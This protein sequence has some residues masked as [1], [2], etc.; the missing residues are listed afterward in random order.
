[1]SGKD[2]RILVIKLGA[3]GDFVQALGPM[4][5]IRH[6]HADARITLLT[7][8]PYRNLALATGV[9]DDVWID[10]RRSA[11]DPAYWLRLRRRLRAGRFAR[12]YDLQTSDRSGW[13]F[14]LFWP[15]PRPEWSGVVAGASHPHENPARDRM[16]TVERQTDQLR[17]AGVVEVRPV[18][19]SWAKADVAPFKLA[20]PYA[21]LAPGGAAHRPEKRWPLERYAA[22]VKALIARGFKPV[23]LGAPIEAALGAALAS[24][25]P[26][27]RDLTGK[28]ALEEIPSLAR[29]AACAVGNDTGPMHLIAAAGCPSV[30]LFSRASDPALCAPRG[31]RV[32]I[33]RSARLEDLPLE[34][35]LAALPKRLTAA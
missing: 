23:I 15:G 3:L 21:L 9:A 25:S 34:E 6:H 30:V 8:A 26:E 2:A 29:D 13:Y 24:L 20:R 28:T 7:T 35:V 33:L 18:D 19:M 4:Q 32:S 5:A 17:R 27:V 10:E 31:D 16:H 1:V 11:L 14:R 12:V 22:L